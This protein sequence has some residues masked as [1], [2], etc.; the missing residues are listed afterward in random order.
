MAKLIFRYDL[1]LVGENVDWHRNSR[2]HTLWEKP[3]LM[4]RAKPAEFEV[5]QGVKFV[6]F[7]GA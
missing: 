1:E 4:V 6:R 2:M 5:A 3:P 7:N